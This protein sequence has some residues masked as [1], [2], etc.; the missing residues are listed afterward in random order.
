MINNDNINIFEKLTFPTN[1]L[2]LIYRM[3]RDGND[4][5]TYSTIEILKGSRC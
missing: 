4:Y 1:K 2:H 3:T 5:W